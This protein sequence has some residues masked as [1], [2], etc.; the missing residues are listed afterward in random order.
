MR[1]VCLQFKDVLEI[2]VFV[3]SIH[4]PECQ[5]DVDKLTVT[6]ALSEAEVEL[7]INGFNA[8]VKKT[9]ENHT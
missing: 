5:V 8:S 4:K 7:A 1:K 9:F 2:L 3:D 6:C